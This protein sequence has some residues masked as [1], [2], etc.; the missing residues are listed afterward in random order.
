MFGDYNKNRELAESL[1]ES[2]DLITL[3]EING[4]TPVDI[5]EILLDR[6][7]IDD[8]NSSLDDE[9]E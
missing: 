5:I 7:L 1:A 6:G 4:L 2:F 3:L 9:L 8:Y